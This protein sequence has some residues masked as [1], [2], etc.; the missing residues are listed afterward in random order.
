LF[1]ETAGASGWALNELPTNLCVCSQINVPDDIK[2][3]SGGI[4]IAV[5][6]FIN[7]QLGN[8][9]MVA[10]ASRCPPSARNVLPRGN[11][12]VGVHPTSHA[13]DDGGFDV[14]GVHD[15]IVSRRT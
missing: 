6:A 15:A 1:F 14:N 9:E 3:F 8:E 5:A 13:S 7:G 11:R 2:S 12:L 4:W 10:I